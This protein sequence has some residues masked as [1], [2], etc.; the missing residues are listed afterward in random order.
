MLQIPPS[1]AKEVQP[2]QYDRGRGLLGALARE[3]SIIICLLQEQARRRQLLLFGVL[4][5]AEE[6]TLSLKNCRPT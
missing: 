4:R 6:S 1:S 5:R 2:P 3:I